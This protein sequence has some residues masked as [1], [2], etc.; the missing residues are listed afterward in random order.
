MFFYCHKSRLSDKTGHE[1]FD[2][3]RSSLKTYRRA[4]VSPR[5][6][7]FTHR[8]PCNSNSLP[9]SMSSLLAL[10]SPA[11]FATR[12]YRGTKIQTRFPALSDDPHRL[13]RRPWGLVNRRFRLE[14]SHNIGGR[15]DSSATLD[16]YSREV[17]AVRAM[18]SAETNSPDA[19]LVVY[20]VPQP[21]IL[22]PRS[23]LDEAWSPWRTK[24]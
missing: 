7:S 16:R 12:R 21:W 2:A 15:F 10:N 3:S 19:Q 13:P 9:S 18:T 4:I 14:R 8:P 17:A 22:P 24:P 11:R 6:W 1:M 5:D 20:Q 23:S